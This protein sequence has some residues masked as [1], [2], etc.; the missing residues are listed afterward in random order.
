MIKWFIKFLY[1]IT[2]YIV[3]IFLNYFTYSFYRHQIEIN[4]NKQ[5]KKF[6]L[7]NNLN[8]TYLVPTLFIENNIL[9]IFYLIS[10]VYKNLI[11]AKSIYGAYN[12]YTIYVSKAIT[13]IL[14]KMYKDTNYFFIYTFTNKVIKNL[15]L[16]KTTNTN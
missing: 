16:Q 4:F 2:S 9:L 5:I 13:I 3:Q 10:K 14:N 8:N 15:K 1:N 11:L 6:F 12:Y 7:T